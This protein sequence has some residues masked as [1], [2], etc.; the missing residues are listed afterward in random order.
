MKLG[1]TSSTMTVITKKPSSLTTTNC[2]SRSLY[3][4]RLPLVA[5]DVVCSG[6]GFGLGTIND[7][8]FHIYHGSAPRDASRPTFTE[9]M[10]GEST[11]LSFPDIRLC[12][13]VGASLQD[14]YV[15]SDTP[16]QYMGTTANKKIRS[17][18]E[19]RGGLVLSERTS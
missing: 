1:T 6:P 17:D 14:L 16:W 8:T 13:D 4:F 18:N 7:M 19:A 11:I 3:P 10:I 5:S 12:I 2:A 15:P 9:I